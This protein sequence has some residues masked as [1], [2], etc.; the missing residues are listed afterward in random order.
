MSTRKTVRPANPPTTPPTTAGVGGL[1]FEE[2]ATAVDDGEPVELVPMLV[3]VPPAPPMP[4]PPTP[5]DDI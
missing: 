1:L 4:T 3:G 2:E 5:V